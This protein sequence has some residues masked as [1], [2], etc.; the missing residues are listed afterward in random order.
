MYA[1]IYTVYDDISRVEKNFY[2]NFY[3]R[4]KRFKVLN[5]ISRVY[6]MNEY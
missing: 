1:Y 6:I 5:N 3:D 4:S 2:L